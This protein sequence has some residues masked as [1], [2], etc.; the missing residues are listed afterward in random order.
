MI[1]SFFR[2]LIELAVLTVILLPLNY[3]VLEELLDTEFK[4]IHYFVYAY[5][6]IMVFIIQMVMM[7]A[8]KN[9]PQRYIIS[10]MSSM[11]IKIFL[12]LIILVVIMYTGLESSKPFAINY[13]ILYL[14]F[15][16]F[17]I[18]QMLRA[19]REFSE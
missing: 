13:L 5:Y 3:F 19:Q 15:S 18:F 10:F 1:G 16:A 6:V 11:G 14:V 17:S 9:R 4:L 8:L 2:F 7:R 12:S